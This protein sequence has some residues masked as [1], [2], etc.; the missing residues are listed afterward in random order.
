MRN[1]ES[2]TSTSRRDL[3]AVVVRS[4]CRRDFEGRIFEDEEGRERERERAEKACLDSSERHREIVSVEPRRK[5]EGSRN[6]IE[7]QGVGGDSAALHFRRRHQGDRG[8]E[9]N[10][11]LR[12]VGP[13]GETREDFDGGTAAESVPGNVFIS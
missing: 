4:R 7:G 1:D 13:G 8:K 2:T 5:L 12:N 11:K 3:W 9:I 6:E 10:G